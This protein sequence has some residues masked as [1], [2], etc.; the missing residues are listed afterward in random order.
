MKKQDIVN[1][2]ENVFLKGRRPYFWIGL[3]G[4][5]I[6]LQSLTFGFTYFDD[7]VLILDNLFFLKNIGNIFKTFTMEVFHVLHSSAAYY[8]PILT[9]SY[10]LDAL[11]SGERPFLYHLTSILIHV[12][13]SILVYIFL[14]KFALKKQ[15]AFLFSVTFAIHPVLIQ[16]VSW[17]PGRNDSLLALFILPA[18]IYYLEFIEKGSLK[19]LALHFLFVFLGL[20]TKESAIFA[21]PLMLILGMIRFDRNKLI[22]SSLFLVT[23]WI[24]IFLFWFYLRSIALLGG[25]V[26]Y[27]FFTASQVIV[28]N[29][30]AVLLYLGK[31]IFPFNL[32]VLPTL[33]DSTLIFGVATLV[34]VTISLAFSKKIDWKIFV[35]GVLWF[36]A[37]LLPAFIRPDNM[38]VADFLEHRIYVPLVGVL[39]VFSQIS[40]LKNIDMDKRMYRLGAIA[41]LLSLATINI[42][43]NRNF[44]DRTTFWKSAVETSPT[45]PLSHKNLGAMYYLDGKMD[46]AKTEFEKSVKLNPFEPMIHNNLGLIYY[47]KGDYKKAEEEYFEELK[48]YPNYDKSFMNLG[49]LYYRQGKK[50]EAEK[51]W[52]KA[53]L[54]NPDYKDAYISLFTLYSE[55]DEVEKA[56]YFY[57]EAVKK[58]AKF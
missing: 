16:A 53:V 24:F 6:Y 25:A 28:S 58:G 33:P 14:S 19:L 43:H 52:L 34:L 40:F 46:E 48:L 54:I 49:L 4:F 32:S 50:D 57:T 8:R 42:I 45:H 23:G 20:F 47:R 21:L 22:N 44:S 11:I 1:N 15:L 17:V 56:N 51:M 29:L 27:D 5:L 7:N 30:P 39:L 38:Y 35:F 41:I 3:S 55:R 36:L 31:I 26:K 2:F 9:V 37:F 10:M 18:C 13:V 12:V